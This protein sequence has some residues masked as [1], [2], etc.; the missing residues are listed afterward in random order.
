MNRKHIAIFPIMVA[1]L[2]SLQGCNFTINF[3]DLTG[4]DNDVTIHGTSDDPN[5]E[6]PCTHLLEEGSDDWNEAM[7][8]YTEETGKSDT[9]GFRLW[10]KSK[11]G[12]TVEIDE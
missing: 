6:C 9:E 5:D 7:K 2:F 1:L 12:Q 8:K 10:L 4:D 11:E 3:V